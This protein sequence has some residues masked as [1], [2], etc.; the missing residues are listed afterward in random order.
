MAQAKRTKDIPGWAAEQAAKK[1]KK[2][3]EDGRKSGLSGKVFED[4]TG[5]EKDTLLKALAVK[6]GLIE[7][8]DDA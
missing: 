3:R 1:A 7:D 4:L 6:A 2:A 5:N 8:S